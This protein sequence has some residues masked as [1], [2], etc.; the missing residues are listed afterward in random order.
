MQTVSGNEE[1]L[2]RVLMRLKARRGGFLPMPEFGSRLHELC[3]M[4]KGERASCAKQF[5]F[6]AL[7]SEKDVSVRDVG[8]AENEDGLAIITVHLTVGGEDVALQMSI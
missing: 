6:E 3:G 2:Q 8:Y 7:E 1:T 4:K 5:V